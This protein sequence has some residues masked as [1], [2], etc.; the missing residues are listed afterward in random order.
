MA[1]WIVTAYVVIIRL[2]WGHTEGLIPGPAVYHHVVQKDN[3]LRR[4]LPGKN[5]Q[6][7][8]P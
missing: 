6:A 3:V 4:M 2:T 8:P 5:A 1:A 7:A